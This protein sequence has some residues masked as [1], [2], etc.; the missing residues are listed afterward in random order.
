MLLSQSELQ[1]L[2]KNFPDRSE[3]VKKADD[4]A[5]AHAEELLRNDVN[6]AKRKLDAVLKEEG[7]NVN[8]DQHMYDAMVSMVYNMGAGKK[9]KKSEFLNALKNGNIVKAYH[10]IDDIDSEALLQ[11]YP[12]LKKRRAK[13]K[14][15]FGRNL[16][17]N[18]NSKEIDDLS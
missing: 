6:E 13:E 12:G 2:K 10:K 14:Q 11:K 3:R 1:Y 16:A 18:N 17:I 5:T 15:R 7:I 9:F 4:I 8:I